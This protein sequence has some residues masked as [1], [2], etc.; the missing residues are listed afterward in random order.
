M[1]YY[2]LTTSRQ[3]FRQNFRGRWERL[4]FSLGAVSQTRWMPSPGPDSTWQESGWFKN[5]P[6]TWKTARA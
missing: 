3:V 4:A 1:D 6:D 2:V 5:L